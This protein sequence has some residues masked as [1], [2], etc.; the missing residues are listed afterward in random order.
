M[1]S[2]EVDAEEVKGEGVRW[3]GVGGLPDAVDGFLGIKVLPGDAFLGEY[4]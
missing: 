3:I 1:Q 2:H 4:R